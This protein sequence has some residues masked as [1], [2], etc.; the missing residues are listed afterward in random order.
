M[1]R[2]APWVTTKLL[3]RQQTSAYPHSVRT[4]YL[5][6][7]SHVQA[8]SHLLPSSAHFLGMHM[9]LPGQPHPAA[10]CFLASSSAVVVR[11]HA[12]HT[13][14]FLLAAR[15]EVVIR[16]HP[17]GTCV[18]G[19]WAGLSH[20]QPCGLHPGQPKVTLSRARG[21]RGCERVGRRWAHAWSSSIEVQLNA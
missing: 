1:L 7:L 12:D 17:A 11:S 9:Q 2:P 19:N 18:I 14:V 4:P 15:R 10:I 8:T 3:T 16:L 21:S 6:R 13:A 5:R 20:R